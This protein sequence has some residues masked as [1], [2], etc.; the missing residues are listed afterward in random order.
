MDVEWCATSPETGRYTGIGAPSPAGELVDRLEALRRVGEGYLEVNVLGRDYPVLSL[1]FRGDHAVLH[2]WADEE[3]MA[4]LGGDGSV[5]MDDVVEVPI[6][7]DEFPGMFTGEFTSTTDR[8][9]G[10][11]RRFLEDGDS[12]SLGDWYDL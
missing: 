9:L 10:L 2:R 7:E 11:V 1:G 6:A 5:P 3:H 12:E 4:L 8:A